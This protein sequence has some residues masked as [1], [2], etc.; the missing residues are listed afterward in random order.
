[1]SFDKGLT[2]VST[3]ILILSFLKREDMYGYQLMTELQ[4]RSNNVFCLKEGTLYPVLYSLQRDGFLRSY[5]K[6]AKSGRM[7]K[8]YSL[9]E[10]GRK[11]LEK[12]L[13][14]WD[15]F[16]ATLNDMIQET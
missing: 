10:D 7:R 2:S 12:K 6:Q 3:T 5:S 1:M 8:Y 13:K 16:T 14:E 9:T 11:L 4:K 15:V